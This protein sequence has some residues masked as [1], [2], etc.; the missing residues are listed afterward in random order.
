MRWASQ[1]YEMARHF[2]FGAGGVA[3]RRHFPHFFS[4]CCSAQRALGYNGAGVGAA[5]RAAMRSSKFSF[6]VSRGADSRQAW[7]ARVLVRARGAR[8]LSVPDGAEQKVCK[9]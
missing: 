8:C 4:V 7:A 1:R 9:A 5:G 3:R 2:F 6:Q